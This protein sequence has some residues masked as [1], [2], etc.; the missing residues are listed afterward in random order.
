LIRRFTS[1]LPARCQHRPEKA[2]ACDPSFAPPPLQQAAQ[3]GAEYALAKAAHWLISRHSFYFGSAPGRPAGV[4]GGGMTGKGAWLRAV[5]L[6]IQGSTPFGGQIT[7][8]D[9]ESRAQ[10]RASITRIRRRRRPAH[11]RA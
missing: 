8:L 2:K 5:L 4:P 6:T 3:R 11:N 7:P 10:W 1:T 9:S